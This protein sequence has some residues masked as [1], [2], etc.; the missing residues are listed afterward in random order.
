MDL[1]ETLQSLKR[2]SSLRPHEFGPG[3]HM[4]SGQECPNNITK[5]YNL[6]L[7]RER[8]QRLTFIL[9]MPKRK[10]AID[11][12]Q[13]LKRSRSSGPSRCP[14]LPQEIVDRIIELSLNVDTVLG[15]IPKQV[16][17]NFR[18]PFMRVNR[19]C[20]QQTV[21]LVSSLTWIELN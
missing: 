16:H 20:R 14:Q 8:Q 7:A 1:A 19:A 17:D 5:L 18:N 6:E 2:A 10:A 3:N 13:G 15:I 12:K 21:R 11:T 9:K 4:C